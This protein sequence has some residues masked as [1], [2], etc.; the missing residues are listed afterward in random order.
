[1]SLNPKDAPTTLTSR[2]RDCENMKQ[3]HKTCQFPSRPC[4]LK[5]SVV[6]PS[7]QGSRLNSLE[8]TLQEGVIRDPVPMCTSAESRS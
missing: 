5:T 7:P 2:L 1:M 4:L 3:R 8:V 6:C